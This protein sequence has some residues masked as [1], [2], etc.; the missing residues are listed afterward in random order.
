MRV[1]TF[2]PPAPI[3]P[4]VPFFSLP[5]KIRV[6]LSRDRG[7]RGFCFLGSPLPYYFRLPLLN[8]PLNAKNIHMMTTKELTMTKTKELPAKRAPALRRAFYHLDKA[9]EQNAPNP[10]TK[11][12]PNQ[13][14]ILMFNLLKK[15]FRSPEPVAQVSQPATSIS[16]PAGCRKLA[17]DNIP[18]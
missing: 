2:L 17:G 10:P 12:K 4:F 6:H 5:L 18:P 7:I 14:D 15:L 9:L 3:F 11:T 1:S 8:C 16:S 13:P